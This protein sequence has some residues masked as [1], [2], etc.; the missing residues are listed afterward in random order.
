M[1]IDGQIDIM[2]LIHSRLF[3]LVA[4]ASKKSAN[5]KRFLSV[6]GI[7]EDPLVA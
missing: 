4:N 5:G 3:L 1:W 6:S 7:F 2:K